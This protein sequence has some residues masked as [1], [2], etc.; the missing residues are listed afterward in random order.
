MNIL[1]DAWEI[2]AHTY[3]NRLIAINE[4]LQPYGI[5]Y[6]RLT[7]AIPD[8]A[9]LQDE[10][11]ILLPM[12]GD[13]PAIQIPQCVDAIP[14]GNPHPEANLEPLMSDV[15][16]LR[17]VLMQRDIKV[18]NRPDSMGLKP[19]QTEVIKKVLEQPGSLTIA[20]LP[21]GYG[22]T[23]IAQSIAWTLR[24]N[25]LGPAVMISP[26]IS[27]MDD[28]RSQWTVFSDDVAN[29]ELHPVN[30]YKSKF[31]TQVRRPTSVGYDG[32][33]DGGGHRSF[34]FLS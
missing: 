13:L 26:L 33:V 30:T 4:Y 17:N 29:S 19:K 32:R 31:L 12:G 5:E 15:E 16:E 22:K 18:R 3:E 21:T 11:L 8:Q 20:A 34:L 28:Q 27:L 25:N 9:I 7:E 23:R 6:F 10:P 14:A 24:N 1:C 2:T